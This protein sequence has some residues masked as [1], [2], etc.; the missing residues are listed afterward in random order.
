[1]IKQ[2]RI[3]RIPLRDKPR[4]NLKS[5]ISKAG[6]ETLIQVEGGIGFHNLVKLRETGVDVFVT[7]N[8]VFAAE[9][10]LQTIS[11]LKKL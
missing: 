4:G 5:L 3:T 1:M 7:G 9:N 6:T 11:D 10:P 8:T 2:P